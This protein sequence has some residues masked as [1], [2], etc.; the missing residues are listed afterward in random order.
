MVYRFMLASTIDG[1]RLEALYH[2]AMYN[3]QNYFANFLLKLI[4]QGMEQ[5]TFDY[6]SYFSSK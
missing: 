5:E 1:V 4:H 6:H 2:L 3:I